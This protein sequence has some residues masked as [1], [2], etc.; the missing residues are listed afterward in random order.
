MDRIAELLLMNA[1][2][3]ALAT[4]FYMEAAKK[5]NAP[6]DVVGRLKDEYERDLQVVR[7]LEV[8]V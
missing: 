8:G 3:T 6:A 7:D 5:Q 4:Y 2:E 1:R